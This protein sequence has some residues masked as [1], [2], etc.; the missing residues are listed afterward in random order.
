MVMAH[1]S[2]GPIGRDGGKAFIQ[3]SLL[4]AEHVQMLGGITLIHGNRMDAV[5]HPIDELG[6]GNTVPDMGILQILD[7]GRCFLGFF[8]YLRIHFVQNTVA[9]IQILYDGIIN[10]LLFQQHPLME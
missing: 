7:L 1:G 8:H 5:L 10:L 4:P 2:I 9:F 3:G 6:H